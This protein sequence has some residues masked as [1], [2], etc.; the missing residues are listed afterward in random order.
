MLRA[1]KKLAVGSPHPCLSTRISGVATVLNV[2]GFALLAPI[3][4]L[5]E[6]AALGQ[7]GGRREGDGELGASA[8]FGF[9]ANRSAMRFDNFANR[10]QP[11]ARA[12][13]FGREKRLEHLGRCLVVMPQPV[14][15]T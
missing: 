8:D 5:K 15:M 2:K 11:E 13:W 12:T 3:V 9:D 1:R 10:W 14:S 4:G 6:R 7:S